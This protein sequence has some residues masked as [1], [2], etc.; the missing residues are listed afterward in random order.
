MRQKFFWSLSLEIDFGRQ[1]NPPC[2][3]SLAHPLLLS[4]AN[5]L[6]QVAPLLK[7]VGTIFVSPLPHR[8]HA[9]VLM[10]PQH[11]HAWPKRSSR[12]CGTDDLRSGCP[13]DDRQTLSKVAPKDHHFAS[14]R[15]V[16]LTTNV[17]Q[18]PIHRLEMVSVHRGGLIPNYQLRFP[19]QVRLFRLLV[20]I[21]RRLWCQDVCHRQLEALVCCHGI[22]EEERRQSSRG[23]R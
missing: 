17:S 20:D 18:A 10:K 23:H 22:R 19:D 21:A 2:I 12:Q 8:S 9:H 4:F 5:P 7:L 16:H 14:E 11:F 6:E 13:F 3:R 1:R 15:L